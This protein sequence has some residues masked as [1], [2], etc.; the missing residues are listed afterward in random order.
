M[1]LFFL[2]EQTRT[3]T[4]DGGVSPSLVVKPSLGFQLKKKEVLYIS[5]PSS[6]LFL[7]KEG[8]TNKVKVVHVGV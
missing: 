7:K 3:D 4:M 8:G 1:N 5:K 2:G 6:F